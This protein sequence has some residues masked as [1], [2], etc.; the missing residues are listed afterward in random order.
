MENRITKVVTKTGDLG[1]TCLA[2]GSCVWKDSLRINAIGNVDE[3]NSVIGLVV[4]CK[5]SDEIDAELLWIQ[6]ELFNLGSEL[7]VSGKRLIGEKQVEHVEDQIRFYNNRLPSLREF[8]LPGGS[9][10]AA[11]LHVARSVC[12]RA[13]RSVVALAKEEEIS[14]ILVQYLNRLSDL[15]FVY[16]RQANR[17]VNRSDIFW[18]K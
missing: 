1:E 3:L 6:N 12:R 2:D 9:K 10:G 11:L 5:V 16:A 13:E 4:S 7:A 15:F 8:I 14:P 17:L 18:Q